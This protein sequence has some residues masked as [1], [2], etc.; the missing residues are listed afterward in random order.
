MLSLIAFRCVREYGS[1]CSKWT[2]SRQKII[3]AGCPWALLLIVTKVSLYSVQA[4]MCAIQ[5]RLTIQTVK[6]DTFRTLATDTQFKGKVK[7]DMLIRLLEAFVWKITCTHASHLHIEEGADCNCSGR[8]S[9]WIPAIQIRPRDERPLCSLPV[10]PA[11]SARSFSVFLNVHRERLST[12]R[13]AVFE[14]CPQGSYRTFIYLLLVGMKR[15][16]CGLIKSS[17]WIGV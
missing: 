2:A 12:L 1:S 4:I 5:K 8:D 17:C 14:R 11:L 9:K 3:Y 13:T 7:E 15:N 6:N 10:H 16:I